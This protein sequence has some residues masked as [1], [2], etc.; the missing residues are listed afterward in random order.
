MPASFLAPLVAAAALASASTVQAQFAW[1][2]NPAT[3]PVV[4][5]YTAP[6]AGDVT[7]WYLFNSVG[8]TSRIGVGIN[9]ALPT[10]FFLTNQTSSPG[11]SAVLGTVAAGDV[12]RFYL[13]VFATAPDSNLGIFSTDP[14]DPNTTLNG[15]NNHAW[16]VPF[17]GDA[18][19]GIPAGVR[20][21]FE[22][23]VG[24]GDRDWDDHV[25]VFRFP[26]APGII[27]EPATW[28]ML[29]AGFGLVGFALRRRKQA[30]TA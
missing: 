29:I 10:A 11:D 4:A 26:G 16:H 17:A 14:A 2:G 15:G 27:P 28:A 21:G 12:I 20:I 9:G 7:A 24:L 3:P 25:F 30:V 1:P 5:S 19:L 8:F 18:I 6:F 22:D 13:E 23:I